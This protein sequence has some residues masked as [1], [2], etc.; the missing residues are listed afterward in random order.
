MGNSETS[1][2]ELVASISVNAMTTPMT[3]YDV[4]GSRRGVGE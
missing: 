3:T 2:N 1:G 4:T